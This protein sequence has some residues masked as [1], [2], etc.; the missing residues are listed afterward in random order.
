MTGVIRGG[1]YSYQSERA[2]S[3]RS[4]TVSRISSYT[5]LGFRCLNGVQRGGCANIYDY[6]FHKRGAHRRT[7]GKLAS[8]DFARGFL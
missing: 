8:S 2:R 4:G 5:D 6:V 1:T 3:A 7:V